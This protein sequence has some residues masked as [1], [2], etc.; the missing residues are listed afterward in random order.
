M[1][2]QLFHYPFDPA[3][4]TARLALGEAK[5]AFEETVVRPWEDD[6]PVRTLNPTGMPPVVQAQAAG[7]PITLCEIGAVLG[8]IEDE[9]KAPVLLPTDPVERAEARRLTAWFERRFT[10]E[11]AAVLLHERLEKQ[12]LRLGPPEARA[13]R[14]GRE[15]LKHHL[16]EL[17][18]MA[19]ARDWLAGR[20]LSQADLMAAAHL[21]VLD[22][23]GEINW[24]Q[25]PALKLWYSKLKSRPCFRPL[26]ADRFVGVPPSAWYADLDF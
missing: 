24:G 20:R 11:V 2:A 14:D 10:D 8:W 16:V 4:R 21:S 7:R 22:Y 1:S 17:E 5:V 3:S 25:W 9:A 18:A 23:F 6:S 19:A 12:L 13:L 26:L 15:A